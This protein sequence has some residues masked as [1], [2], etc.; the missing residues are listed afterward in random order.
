MASLHEGLPD[1]GEKG[2]FQER[3]CRTRR[4]WRSANSADAVSRALDEVNGDLSDGNK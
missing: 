1:H 4:C 2:L 3:F